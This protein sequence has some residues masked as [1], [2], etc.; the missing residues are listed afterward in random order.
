MEDHI[1]VMVLHEAWEF[2]FCDDDDESSQMNLV[3]K[4]NFAEELVPRF[5]DK[6]F[7][8]HF[9]MK[10]ETFEDLLNKLHNTLE[11]DVEFHAGNQPMPLEKQ[12]MITIWCLANM[13][14]FR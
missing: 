6:V 14:S 12:L 7:Q 10:P 5:S 13:E 8:S 4:Q 1:M 9:R 11:L 2:L 3:S